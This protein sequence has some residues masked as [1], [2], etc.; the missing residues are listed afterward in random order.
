M[1]LI[2]TLDQATEHLFVVARQMQHALDELIAE[3]DSVEDFSNPDSLGI[4]MAREA[5]KKSMENPLLM[6]C[7]FNHTENFREISDKRPDLEQMQQ[8]VGGIVEIII[9]PNERQMFCDE[10]GMLKELPVNGRA[11]ILAGHLILGKVVILSGDARWT[12]DD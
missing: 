2:K 1:P 12:E 6:D 10:E 11:S 3:Q 8:M 7:V 4:T 5:I 9:L